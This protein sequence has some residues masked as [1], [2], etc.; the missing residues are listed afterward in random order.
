MRDPFTLMTEVNNRFSRTE[1]ET[2]LGR[3]VRTKFAID[4]IPAGTTGYV[5]QID[6]MERGGYELI[7]EWYVLVNGR[8][9]H[10]WFGKNEYDNELVEAEERPING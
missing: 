5:M 3:R 4:G 9:Q 10:N 6:E 7:V 2:R 1:A 8:H